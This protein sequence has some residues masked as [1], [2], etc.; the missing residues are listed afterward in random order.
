MKIFK[1]LFCKHNYK[2]IENNYSM[3]GYYS[4][5]KCGKEKYFGDNFQF[6]KFNLK[7]MVYGGL[8]NADNIEKAK[9]N[10]DANLFI[11]EERRKR[12]I[13]MVKKWSK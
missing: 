1:G 9:H 11:E 12:E 10:N 2:P 4:C 3:L 5:G 7:T 6:T 13:E 8:I